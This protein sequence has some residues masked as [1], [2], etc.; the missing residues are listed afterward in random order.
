MYR[1]IP[2]ILTCCRLILT[3]PILLLFMVAPSSSRIHLLVFCLVL[4]CALSDIFDGLLARLWNCVSDFGKI[5]DP[6]ADK[7]L[8]LLFLPLIKLDLIHFLPVAIL[9]MRDI[10]S[11]HLRSLYPHKVI[12]AKLSGK[13]KTIVNLTFLCL[14]TAAIPVEHSYFAFLADYGDTLYWSSGS[15]IIVVSIVSGVD[16]HY[17]IV[18]KET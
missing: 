17:Q 5:Y 18:V 11:T 9:L 10:Y 6:L 7:W 3:I 8:V 15:L 13:V 14:L 1:R 12:A 4:I 16:Y 2:N